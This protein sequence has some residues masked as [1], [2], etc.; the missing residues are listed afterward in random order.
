M[1][2]RKHVNVERFRD[3][4]RASTPFIA[5]KSGPDSI[6]QPLQSNRANNESYTKDG[7]SPFYIYIVKADMIAL[8]KFYWRMKQTLIYVNKWEPI[9]PVLVVKAD[10]I[11]LYNVWILHSRTVWSIIV[12]LLLKKNNNNNP[13]F[14][15]EITTQYKVQI[16]IRGIQDYRY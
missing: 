6:V 16:R 15:V 4:K 12:H 1:S 7:A 5:C 2:A 10:I 11:A 9:F 8:Y 3:W 13:L 14:I